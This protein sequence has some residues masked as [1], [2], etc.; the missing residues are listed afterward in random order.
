[1]SYPSTVATL[2]NPNATDKLNSP[3]HHTVETNQNTEVTAIE[4]FVGTLSSTAGTLIYDIRAA[5]SNGGG[6]VQTA[7]KGGTGQT[8]Y[9]KGDLLVASSSSVLS[10]LTVGT[11]AYVLTADS[12]QNTGV[13]WVAATTSVPP[14][15]DEG[16]LT[17][18]ASPSIQ[19]LTFTNAGKDVYAMI[20]RIYTPD[21]QPPSLQLN[22]VSASVYSQRTIGSSD[23]TSQTAMVFGDGST[24]SVGQFLISGKHTSGIKMVNGLI[25]RTY[26]GIMT[27][28]SN[29]LSSITIRPENS[30]I[31]GTIHFYSLTL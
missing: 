16:S 1:M 7:N 28:D 3:A 31:T 11:D 27:G 2:T 24:V 26:G 6:H 15:V 14:W 21:S 20:S 30:S 19:S 12:S 23:G 4:T 5:A 29:N 10:K 9:S 22:G 13:K 17:W 8:S 18:S 25:G